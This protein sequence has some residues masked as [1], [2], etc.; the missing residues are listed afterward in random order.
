[1]TL[2]YLMEN[3]ALTYSQASNTIYDPGIIYI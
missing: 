3:V 1:M 2:Y